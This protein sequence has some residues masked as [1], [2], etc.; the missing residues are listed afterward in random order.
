MGKK[1]QIGIN[2]LHSQKPEL[3]LEWHPTKNGSLTPQMVS[4][5]SSKRVWWQRKEYRFGKEFVLEW[6]ALV[7]NRS[8]GSDCPYTSVPPRKLLVGF[9]DLQST[10]PELA[11]KWHPDKNGDL[12][13]DMV[14]ENTDRH[15]WWQH[16]TFRWGK[17]FIHEWQ[18]SP[19]DVKRGGDNC[20]CPICHGTKVLTGYNDL[21][22]FFPEL[23]EEW[24]YDQNAAL[25]LT[26]ETVTPGSNK[27]VHWICKW[28]GHSWKAM[29]LNRTS[30]QSSCPK[31]SQRTQTSFPE[32]A[33]Y[34]Y[35][36]KVWWTH[37][38]TQNNVPSVHSWEASP[39]SRTNMES[40]CPF[41]S[42]K[43]VLPGFNDL[44]TRIPEI[45]ALW[46]YDKN[47]PMKPC[48]FTAASGKKVYWTD[49]ERTIKI[50]DRTKYLRNKKQ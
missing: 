6:D 17:E 25:G 21:L 1:L 35:F 7:S 28:C 27:K 38:I 19:K 22:T 9:N 40:G 15:V 34:Y 30:K 32:Q 26:P 24:D 10:N 49:R 45:A 44:E 16:K 13:P 14:F 48:E 3:A 29:I 33:I 42:N 50:C 46:D 36:K 23:C 47:H 11:E 43:K 8:N 31:C 20:G 41:C 12:K 18:A 2:D 37:T 5:F 39:N 4:V